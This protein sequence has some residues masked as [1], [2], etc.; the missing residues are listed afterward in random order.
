MKARNIL[1]AFILV[2]QWMPGPAFAQYEPS[3]DDFI[4]TDEYARPIEDIQSLI[5]YPEE[6]KEEGIEGDVVV[7]VLINLEG[8]VT[9]VEIEKSD[10]ELL[11]E[12]AVKAARQVRFTPATYR[13]KLVQ[14]WFT[15]RL[16]FRLKDGNLALVEKR[17][18]DRE[19]MRSLPYMI[20]DT[21]SDVTKKPEALNANILDSLLATLTLP[22][23][24]KKKL[25]LR[26]I[27]GTNG[28][29]LI[30]TTEESSFSARVPQEFWEAVKKLKFSPGEI[31]Y[32]HTTMWTHYT[33]IVK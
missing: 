16:L 9:K 21:D 15:Q 7:A 2:V 22:S 10:N 27:I 18:V 17:I 25:V 24:E 13:G 6:A 30:S 19:T 8:G 11:A 12:A 3:K 28:Q 26:L 14:V 5:L 4:Y 31:N 32:V 1:I 29:V 20:L 23:N 33:L